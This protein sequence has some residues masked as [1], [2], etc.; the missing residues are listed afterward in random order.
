[1]ND[2]S[3]D[4]SMLIILRPLYINATPTSLNTETA[5]TIARKVPQCRVRGRATQLGSSEI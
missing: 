1:M 2:A 5:F 3:V 4:T